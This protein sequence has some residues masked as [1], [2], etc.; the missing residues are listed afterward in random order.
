MAK[1]III[2]GMSCNH[3]VRHVTTALEELGL[4]EVKVDLASKSAVVEGDASDEAIKA[5]I[6]D[7]G[8]D[9]V[10]IKNA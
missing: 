7:A 1:K 2:E 5:P 4:S 10:E 9:V 8:Y 6:E 3:C